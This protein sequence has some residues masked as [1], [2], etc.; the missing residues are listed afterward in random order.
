MYEKLDRL[1]IE[2]ERCKKRIE[3]DKVKLKNAEAKLHE[4]ENTQ[5]L[6]D[7]GE[8]NLTP[9][10]LAE[11]LVHITAGIFP[12]KDTEAGSAEKIPEAENEESD[13]EEEEDDE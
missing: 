3:D 9:E 6:A 10:Q 4:A 11:F 2:V 13:E 8:Y 1:R 12:V 7:V 5:I